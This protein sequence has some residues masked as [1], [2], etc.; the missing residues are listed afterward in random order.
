[1]ALAPHPGVHAAHRRAHHQAQVIDAQPFGEQAVLRFDHV[2]VAVLRKLRAQAVAGLGGLA[3]AD[4]VGQHDEV[5]RGVERLARAK[6]L[7]GELGPDELRAAAAGAVPDEHGVAHDSLGILFRRC[8]ACGSESS[9]R[10]A[11]APFENWKSRN[12][13]SPSTGAG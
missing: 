6:Q 8:P 1:M 7:A 10:A 3:V 5:A 13:K 4:A 11:I 9:V 2:G 12:T